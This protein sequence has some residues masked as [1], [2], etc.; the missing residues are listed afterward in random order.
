MNI[1]QK[2]TTQKKLVIHPLMS[3]RHN[4]V[5]NVVTQQEA[6]LSLGKAD[7]TAYVR[8]PVSELTN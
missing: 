6:Q 8:S 2:I 5:I 7:C 4:H 1:I 3:E